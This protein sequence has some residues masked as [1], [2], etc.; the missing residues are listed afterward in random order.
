VRVLNVRFVLVNPSLRMLRAVRLI[1][2]THSNCESVEREL[3]KPLCENVE[4]HENG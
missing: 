3:C 4:G 2:D 1:R